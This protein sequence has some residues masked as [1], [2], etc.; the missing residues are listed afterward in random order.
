MGQARNL[1]SCPILRQDAKIF[2]LSLAS[3]WRWI[4]SGKGVWSWARWLSI[5]EQY[6]ERINHDSHGPL[7]LSAMGCVCVVRGGGLLVLSPEITVSTTKPGNFSWGHWVRMKEKRKPCLGKCMYVG[8]RKMLCRRIKQTV[9]CGRWGQLG[10]SSYKVF[11]G[12]WEGGVGERTAQT[13]GCSCQSSLIAGESMLVAACFPML[14][15]GEIRWSYMFY[16]R[17]T[18]TYK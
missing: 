18:C 14:N 4:T 13:P 15:E 8:E 5:Q 12:G 6:L 7:A 9:S 1:P 11:L 3:H 17:D 16:L 10:S 2:V